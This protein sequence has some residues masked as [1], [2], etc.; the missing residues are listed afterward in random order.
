MPLEAPLVRTRAPF[1]Y[2]SIAPR[3][4]LLGRLGMTMSE[5]VWQLGVID[6]TVAKAIR[7]R[8][9]WRRREGVEPSDS[10]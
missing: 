10:R 1:S 5:I 7:W 4:E 8:P 3:A 6:K 2:Q 9:S